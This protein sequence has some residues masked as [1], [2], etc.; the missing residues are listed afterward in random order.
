MALISKSTIQPKNEMHYFAD[1]HYALTGLGE[2]LTLQSSLY[3]YET[4]SYVQSNL[5]LQT[6]S[7]AG[8]CMT[9]ASTRKLYARLWSHSTENIT[10]PKKAICFAMIMV[11]KLLFHI[12]TYPYHSVGNF[13][14]FCVPGFVKTFMW[15]FWTL[16]MK[17]TCH[18][19][20]VDL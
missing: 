18:S 9:P 3:F 15:V 4:L 8:R 16:A 14:S 17:W 12:Y 2:R 10:C 20:A 7:W 19:N 11:N 13:R 6:S 1:K 5:L